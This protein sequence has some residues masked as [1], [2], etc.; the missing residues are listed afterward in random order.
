[1]KIEEIK[2]FYECFCDFTV[3]YIFLPENFLVTAAENLIANSIFV[4]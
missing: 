4:S 3:C 2:R 1:M